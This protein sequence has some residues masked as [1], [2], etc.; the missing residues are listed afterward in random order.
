MV[1]ANPLE[2]IDFYK[3]VVRDISYRVWV[4]GEQERMLSIETEIRHPYCRATL[5][6]GDSTGVIF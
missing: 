2:Y 5:V 4:L 3:S 6:N 1:V